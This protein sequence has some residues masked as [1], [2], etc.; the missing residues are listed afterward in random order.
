MR[1]IAS[2][3]ALAL[4]AAPPP[5]LAE[6]RAAAMAY[7]PSDQETQDRAVVT[8]ALHAASLRA[9][10]AY[11]GELAE[12][13]RHA[14]AVYPQ[15]EK[16]GDTTILRTNAS[17]GNVA[18]AM[19]MTL[20]G[21]AKDGQSTSV[22]T[23]FNTY[24]M[25]V[26]LLGSMANE[27]RDPRGA[28]AYLDKG[29]A[30]QPNNLILITEKG[31]AL[32][33][34]QRF[35]DALDLYQAAERIDDVSKMLDPGGEAR[36]LRSKGFVLIELN[37]LDEAET[38]YQTALKLEPDH[39]GAKGELDYIRKLRAGGP[40]SAIGLFTGDKAKAGDAAGAVP[41]KP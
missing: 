15:I 29:L 9:A 41:V 40:Q 34:L 26:L 7:K 35:S 5:A 2:L 4:T 31:M 6:A 25:A 39:A 28:I 27:R 24:A 23:T 33:V 37:R 8:K 3:L 13:W 22:A 11:E 12:V 18:P 36:L 30:L 19:L 17:D 10:M 14:P 21:A 32:T 20:I 38:A 1:L 16:R